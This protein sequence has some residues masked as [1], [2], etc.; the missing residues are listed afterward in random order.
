MANRA[1]NT[2]TSTEVIPAGHAALTAKEELGETGPDLSTGRAALSLA[3]LGVVFGDIGTSPV[4]TFRECFNPEHG[5]PLD[6][7]HVLG[8]LSMIFWALIIVVTIKYVLLIMRADNQGEGGILALLALALERG[9]GERSRNI[10]VLLALGGA[11]LFYG[12]SMITPAISVLS[13]V[14]GIGVAAPA[15]NRFV[16]PLTVVVLLALFLFQKGGTGRVGSIFGPVM[17]LWFAVIGLIGVMQIAD[18]PRVLEALNPAHAAHIFIATPAAGFVVLGAVALAITGGE[19]LYADMGHFGR[20]PIRLAWFAVVLPALVL[21]YFGQGALI[22]GDKTAIDNPFFRMAPAWGLFPLVLLSTAATVIASQAVISGAFSLSRQAIQLGLMPPLDIFQT[23]T[24]THGQI[25]IAQINW[26]LLIAV[27]ALVLG[28]QSSSALASAYGFAVTGTMAITSVLAAAVMRGVWR[29]QW[30]T[31]AV[32]LVPIMTVDLALFGA[33]TLKIPSGGWFPL[34][35]GIAVFT[36]LTTWRT[37]RRLVRMQLASEAVPL[38]SFLATCD[39]APEARVSGTAVFLTTQT[40]DV[41]LTLLRNL[42][43]NKVLHRTVLLVHV[44]TENIPRVAGADRIKARELGSGFWQ[45]E[46]HF[47]FAQTPNVARELQRAE[48]PGLELDPSQISFFVGRANVKPSPRPG[49]ARWRE[50]LYSALARVATR[51]PD[52]FRIPPDRVIELGTEVE[53]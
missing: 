38:A 34:V 50:R 26:L 28:F 19:A 41:P 5:L 4:Y 24:R 37:G 17:V 15:L 32:V 23:S 14:E 45:I 42:K 46:A 48:I 10:L 51:S 8:V 21:N 44:V 33:N 22:L 16:L 36:I 18:T 29:W 20:F 1:G 13:A 7:E 39:Q 53:I 3:A 25:Y 2:A 40:E 35:I 47:G 6:A 12:D 27:V 30:P 11:A 43:H 52:F 31:I 49:M 9:Q